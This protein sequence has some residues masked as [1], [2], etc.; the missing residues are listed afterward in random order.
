MYDIK[1]NNQPILFS[2]N[3]IFK[4]VPKAIF[5]VISSIK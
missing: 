3:A 5:L 2:K 4:E 1:K